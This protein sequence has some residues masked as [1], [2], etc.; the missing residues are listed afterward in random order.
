M[1]APLVGKS[2]APQQTDA[3]VSPLKDEC[4]ILFGSNAVRM[5]TVLQP[6]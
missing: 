1:S 4:S 6:K 2:P 3:H 5:R